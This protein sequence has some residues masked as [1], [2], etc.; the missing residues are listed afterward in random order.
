MI[1]SWN[2]LK[3]YVRLDMSIDALVEKLM[4][5]GLN[6]EGVEEV[7]G[8]FA[9]DL[10][11]TSNRPDCLG[12]LGIAREVAALFGR[13]M[14]PPPTDFTESA[15]PTDSLTRVTIEP[16]AADWCPQYRARVIEGVAI[17]PSPDW[18]QRRLRSVGLAAI[19]NVVDIT[20]YVLF[21]C[22]QPLHAFDYDKLA[23]KRIVVRD[24]R[25]KEP[26][27]AIN[28]KSYELT[29]A[30]GVIADGERAVALAGV[31]G[32]ADTEVTDATRTVLLESAEFAPLTIRSAGR[33]LDLHSDSS[34]RFERK[35]DPA[36]VAWASDRACH[37]LAELAGGKVARGSLHEG[38]QT[39]PRAPVALRLAQVPRVLGIEVPADEIE[40][41]LRSL[42]LEITERT[43]AAMTVVPP[44]SRRDIT[45]EIDLV[46]EI[47]RV[48][49]YDAVPE[50]RVIPLSVS[51]PSKQ[52]RVSDK[53]RDRLC[54]FGYFEAITF[55]F[56]DSHSAATIRPWSG[57]DALTVVH[58]SRKQENRLRQSVLPSLLQTL[59][60]N[61]S[62]GVADAA[63]FE[64]SQVFLPKPQ[65]TL[66]D[67][68]TVV[69]MATECDLRTLRGHVESLFD[70]LRVST[71]FV[72]A[73]TDGLD[74]DRSAE[75]RFAGA[76]VGVIGHLAPS[77]RDRF[78]LT[79]DPV[80]AEFLL[81]PLVEAAN[82]LPR[83][84]PTPDQPAMVRDLNFVLDDAVRWADLE[85]LVREVAGP[86]MERLEFVD[87][88]RGKPIEAGKKSM[89]LR[90][91]YR[92]PDRTLT[93]TE[94]DAD[95][96]IV[97]DAVATKLAGVLR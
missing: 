38:S 17:G 28:N 65:A 10:E 57:A 43:D 77:V 39:H 85:A 83:A 8:D 7:D 5:S 76:R 27:L 14:T 19:N 29:P 86:R 80:V 74:P 20:N 41:I 42:G 44:T 78:E 67:E 48:H 95:Q 9:I 79:G 55:T 89:V 36:G 51:P 47:G 4:M 90:L 71:E 31:M 92:A 72:P 34:Y 15:T 49:G 62:R 21:E 96:Q 69:G 3:Q 75:Y 97:I 61:E 32:G 52:D 23:E 24:A 33:T 2:W 84:A 54:G 91:T 18:M 73:P 46:E 53:V 12:H 25:G 56:T 22:G 63:L 88:Y 50:D 94:V 82:L 11:V 68:P 59:R 66:P 26:F 60:L 70:H 35:I 93:R 37:L 64:V 30:M 13:E 58:S 81:G 1:V 16:Q 40:R 6:L 45:R 87:L